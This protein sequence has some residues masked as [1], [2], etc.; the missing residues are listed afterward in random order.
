MG[1][2]NI[3]SKIPYCMTVFNFRPK[4]QKLRGGFASFWS[5]FCKFFMQNFS[6]LWGW[7]V[8]LSNKRAFFSYTISV[9]AGLGALFGNFFV[10]FFVILSYKISAFCEA[11][12][13]FWVQKDNFFHAKL[14]FLRVW[15]VFLVPFFSTFFV[16]FLCKNSVF[17]EAGRSFWVKKD[18]IFHAKLK[19]LRGWVAFLSKKMRFFWVFLESRLKELETKTEAVAR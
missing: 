9:F 1:V 18:N 15:V 6:F 11:G 12:R 16:I 19:F 5:I 17:S 10:D 2:E 4:L 13:S 3:N 7:K 14:Q 8:I